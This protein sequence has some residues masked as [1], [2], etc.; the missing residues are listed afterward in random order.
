VAGQPPVAP[1]HGACNIDRSA[2]TESAGQSRASI[3]EAE[4]RT[5]MAAL[6]PDLSPRGAQLQALGEL[7]RNGPAA[8]AQRR[9]LHGLFGPAVKLAA[10]GPDLKPVM[11]TGPVQLKLDD[12]TRRVRPAEKADWQAVLTGNGY[13][14]LSITKISA[15]AANPIYLAATHAALLNVDADLDGLGHLKGKKL[16]RAKDGIKDKIENE[17]GKILTFAER[18]LDAANARYEAA[19]KAGALIITNLKSSTTRTWDGAKPLPAGRPLVKYEKE[20]V[21][22]PLIGALH[23]PGIGWVT[24][25]TFRARV[26]ER[27]VQGATAAPPLDPL[28]AAAIATEQGRVNTQLGVWATVANNAPGVNANGTWGTSAGGA[29]GGFAITTVS[30]DVWKGLR[31]WWIAKANAI[32]TPSETSTWSLKMDRAVP[33]P[34]LSA[35]FNYHI[36]V[37]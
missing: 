36:N 13:G 18:E 22:P 14:P 35:R 16:K 8:V 4:P 34:A 17:Y 31:K 32:V 33:N 23:G 3:A 28:V 25:E 19:L 37:A 20:T 1:N 21:L 6:S 30:A 24:L 26:M 5:G 12:V 29:G 7:A 9:T 15:L 2:K 11:T 27:Y 10:A